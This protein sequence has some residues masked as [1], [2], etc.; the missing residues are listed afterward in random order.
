[1]DTGW[2]LAAVVQMFDEFCGVLH[3]T[4]DLQQ[5]V[6]DCSGVLLQAHHAGCQIW[7]L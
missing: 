5:T 1:M 3:K 4:A 2:L 7:W 6:E